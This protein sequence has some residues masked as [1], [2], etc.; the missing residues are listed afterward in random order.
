MIL[1]D[2]QDKRMN[3]QTNQYWSSEKRLLN[4]IINKLFIHA[5]VQGGYDGICKA[6]Q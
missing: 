5:F 3:E 2:M 1:V 6:A 4:V